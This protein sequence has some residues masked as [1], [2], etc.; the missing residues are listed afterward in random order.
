MYHIQPPRATNIDSRT[1]EMMDIGTSM[2]INRNYVPT[3]SHQKLLS[4]YRLK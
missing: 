4:R 2:H 3:V 1:D